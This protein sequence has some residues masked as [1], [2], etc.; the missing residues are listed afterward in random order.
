MEKKTEIKQEERDPREVDLRG[1]HL[2]LTFG[3]DQY[4][5]LENEVCLLADLAERLTD[6]GRLR[7]ICK[8][9]RILAGTDNEEAI[10]A[11]MWPGCIRTLTRAIWAAIEEGMKMETADDAEQPEVVDV[12]LEE[13]AKKDGRDS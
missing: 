9:T 6:K 11:A 3:M 7:T 4:E 10:W 2:K 5:K 8:V 12:T 13:I 1:L